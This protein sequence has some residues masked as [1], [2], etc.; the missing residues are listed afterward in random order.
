MTAPNSSQPSRAMVFA[1][2]QGKLAVDLDLDAVGKR[3]I[4]GDED[5]LGAAAVFGLGEEIGGDPGGVGGPVGDDQHF[6]RAGDHV[7]ADRAEDLPLGGGDIGIAGADDLVDRRQWSRCH[8]RAR[9]TAC[10]PPTR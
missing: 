5:R 9:A 3:R 6:G 10:A 7:D 1:R 8:R 2:Q 4:G